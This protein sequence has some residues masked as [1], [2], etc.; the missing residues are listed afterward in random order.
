MK[1]DY[2]GDTDY[3]PVDGMSGIVSEP[4]VYNMASAIKASKFPMAVDTAPVNEEVTNTVNRLAKAESNSG[5]D[6]FLC[7]ILV[8]FN[9]TFS[10]K[11]WVEA[12]RYHWLSIVS[13][14]STMHR[15]SK[16]E[17]PGQYSNYVDDEIVEVMMR[18]QKRYNET[19]S[20]EDY[21][22]LL[23][24]NPAGF[25]LTAQIVTNYRQLKTVYR[26]RANHTLPEWRQFCQWLQ[27]LPHSEW[28]TRKEEGAVA[29]G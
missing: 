3:M 20:K 29:N 18:L 1:Y 28:I 15:I 13:S 6:N 23:Y 24:S 19:K 16:F 26:Q 5:E 4:T 14:Q 9:L 8:K 25:K 2:L 17:L 22:R 11:A 21:L 10:N 7:G 27:T 12:E